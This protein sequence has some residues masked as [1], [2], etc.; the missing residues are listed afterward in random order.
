MRTEVGHF[1]K[2]C[3]VSLKKSLSI[4]DQLDLLHARGMIID[5]PIKAHSFLER[6]HYYRLNI[7]FH[8][9]MDSPNH[10]QD[11]IC[12]SEIISVYE[13][14]R[15]L[16][17]KILS[18]L[19]PIEIET[20]TRISYHLA[21]TYGSSALYQSS[22]F[23]V[24]DMYAQFIDK[25]NKDIIHNSQDPVIRH[26]QKKYGGQFPVWVAIEYLSFNSLSKLYKNLLERDK[27]IIAR[28]FYKTN[29]YLLGQW[30]HTLS[31]LRNICAH[32]GYLFRREF[33][34][35]PRIPKNFKW[36]SS[37]NN[38]LFALFLVMRSLSDPD[39]WGP[40]IQKLL[41]I[42]KSRDSFDLFDYGF[43]KDWPHFLY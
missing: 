18:I 39:I 41:T 35:R 12:F 43:P 4:S 5:D 28:G 14:D 30:L 23:K 17:N 3:S 38:K 26:H 9:F 20:R 19:E 34:I 42:E 15:W 2:S 13:N 31:I 11:G 27:K 22:N 29:D 40:F 8:K 1:L 10:F 25:F 21:L 33:S 16:R 6:N 37:Q 7:Y 32:Y 36:N 24:Y